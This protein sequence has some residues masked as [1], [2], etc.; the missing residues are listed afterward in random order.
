[1]KLFRRAFWTI[2]VLGIPYAVLA[3]NY[4]GCGAAWV[5]VHVRALEATT[6]QPIPA[7]TVTLVSERRAKTPD[8]R[9]SAPTV[10]S[11]QTDNTGH[12]TLKDMF[13]AGFD[14][15][16]T[17]IYVGASSLHC[18]AEGYSSAEARIAPSPRLRFRDFLIYKQRSTVE[19]S[20]LLAR[21]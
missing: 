18:E 2:L 7:A 20:L 17:S 1:M 4:I 9:V 3:P 6:R 16:G 12:A 11:A 21:Q 10:L 14:K 19:V 5:T 13:G 8:M 15:W